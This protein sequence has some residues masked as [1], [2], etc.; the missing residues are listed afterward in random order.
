MCDLG[1]TIE[2]TD[3]EARIAQLNT[4]MDARGLTFRDYPVSGAT[5]LHLNWRMT[6]GR[7]DA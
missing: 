3:L 5:V 1:V 6:G 2:G 4:E 7:S